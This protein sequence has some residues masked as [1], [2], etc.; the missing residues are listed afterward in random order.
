MRLAFISTILN[1]PWGG[2]DTM[3]TRAAEAAADR[4]DELFISVSA[5]VAA[6]PRVA[7]LRARG[8]HVYERTPA[9]I[10]TSIRARMTRKIG[11]LVRPVDP[12]LRA[13]EQFR[14]DWVVISLGGT[15]DLILHPAWCDWFA[16]SGTKYRL[17]A[18]WQEENPILSEAE[19]ALAVRA[20]TQAEQVN[21]V[22]TRNMAVTRRHLLQ[23][24]P[25]ARVLQN[26]LR[27]QPS[28]VSDW[29]NPSPV[30][31]ATVS[32][33]DENK[34][35]QLL[36]HALA[37]EPPPGD[38]QLKIHGHGPAESYLRGVVDHLRLSAHVHFRGHVAS[39]REI[40]SENHLLVS[41]SIE[42]GVPMTIPEALLCARPVL[43]TAVGGA[44][45]W[46]AD[47]ES[48]FLCPAPTVPLLAATLRKALAAT[49]RWPTM[50]TTGATAAR[51]R[52]RAADYLQLI[53]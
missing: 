6:S 32:R 28:D 8:A 1:Y 16:A 20:L 38:W 37:A 3:W 23:A 15:Y 43:A 47:G 27:W 33:L 10:P 48:G 29:P 22:S 46:L 42:D 26:P 2:A 19:R 21:F 50:G 11:R 24:L 49:D 12:L 13:L 17:V 45:D 5:M 7:A 52:Y 9:A 40:W 39:L 34:G 31:L 36:L 18:N 25:N 53:A 4:G 44:E 14:P 35:I 51:E 41:P 30:C